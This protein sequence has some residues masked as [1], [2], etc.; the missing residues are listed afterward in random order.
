MQDPVVQSDASMEDS[1]YFLYSALLR[2]SNENYGRITPM[3]V[4]GV[5]ELG[6]LRGRGG[7]ADDALTTLSAICS[8]SSESKLRIFVELG[9][10]VQIAAALTKNPESAELAILAT[11]TLTR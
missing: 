1:M 6:M 5:Q 2:T 9:G 11:D 10:L 8:P 3:V 7:I 4:A